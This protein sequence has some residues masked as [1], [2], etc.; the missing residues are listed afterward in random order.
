MAWRSILNLSVRIAPQLIG[1]VEAE[2]VSPCNAARVAGGTTVI[3]VWRVLD[4][5][6]GEYTPHRQLLYPTVSRRRFAR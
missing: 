1:I 5:A 4:C 2:R 3:N 6:R